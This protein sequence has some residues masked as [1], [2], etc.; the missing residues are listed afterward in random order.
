MKRMLLIFMAASVLGILAACGGENRS[1]EAS[2]ISG[3]TPTCNAERSGLVMEFFSYRTDVNNPQLGPYL[4]E[5][6]ALIELF[7]SG[8]WHVSRYDDADDPGGEPSVTEYRI[9]L[10]PAQITD[11]TARVEAA[12]ANAEDSCL[13][14][15]S[16][17][18]ASD[19]MPS[20]N[21][22]TFQ[23]QHG[24]R[25]Y[26]YT[27]DPNTYDTKECTH[28]TGN[29]ADVPEHLRRLEDAYSAAGQALL[30]FEK[31]LGQTPE[32]HL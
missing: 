3:Y 2:W 18:I 25:S 27:W 30:T 24:L 4:Q 14:K 32:M 23:S 26:V 11:I 29:P 15:K 6:R 9:A 16:C 13:T 12:L 22:F 17:S 5:H 31:E 1:P 21:G 8:E 28:N 19:S 20:S 10:T 7:E